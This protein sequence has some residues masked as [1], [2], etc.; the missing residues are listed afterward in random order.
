MAASFASHQKNDWIKIIKKYIQDEKE[1]QETWSET[2]QKATMQTILELAT[3]VRQFYTT[4]PNDGQTPL[5]FAARTGKIKVF[6]DIFEVMEKK[7]PSDNKG[8]TP[9]HI[10]A[11]NGHVMICRMIVAMI[12]DKNP[13]NICGITPLHVAAQNGHLLVCQLII[14][15]VEDKNPKDM[16]GDTPLHYAA[17]YGHVEIAEKIV[18]KVGCK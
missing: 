6:L 18:E 5:H 17:Q 4:Y 16:W 3:A 8:E 10:A 14:G 12:E 1:F 7:N 9:L 2:L 15:N 13:K 11:E